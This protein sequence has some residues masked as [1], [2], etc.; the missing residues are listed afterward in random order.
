MAKPNR[1]LT[2]L[3]GGWY[4]HNY[5][6]AVIDDRAEAEQAAE[7]LSSAGWPEND[8][9]LFAGQ[10]IAPR[11]E[12]IEEQRSLPEK[13]A[14]DVRHYVSDE[15]VMAE[16]Y[17]EDARLGHQILAIYTPDDAKV[18]QARALLAAHHAHSI[19]HFGTWVITDLPQADGTTRQV[20]D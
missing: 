8:I 4:P 16:D 9:R 6:V 18:E 12:Q 19:E 5:I 13:L 7:A 14:A 20:G 15:G 11:L 17:E 10:K 2:D 3:L 1:F